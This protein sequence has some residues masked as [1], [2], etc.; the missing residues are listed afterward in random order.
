[1][2][3]QIIVGTKP[4]LL[5]ADSLSY[6]LCQIVQVKDEDTGETVDAWK[7]FK[8]F[9]SLS[10]AMNRILDMKIRASDATSLSELAADLETARAEI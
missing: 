1:M 6:E 8:Y 3:I 4:I 5:R 10:Q 2:Q 9:A 7:P